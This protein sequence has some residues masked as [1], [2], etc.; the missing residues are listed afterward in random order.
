MTMKPLIGITVISPSY[1]KV[2]AEA[3]RRFKKF[4]GREVKV[5]QCADVDGYTNKLNLDLLHKGPMV[6][7]DAD[8]WLLREWRPQATGPVWTAC[9]DPLVAAPFTFACKDCDRFNLDKTRY[10]NSGLFFCDT[11]LD[12]HRA[13]FKRA[14]QMHRE[15]ARSTL[16]KAIDHTDQGWLNA[17][18]QHLNVPQAFLPFAYNYY[19]FGVT[20]GG[21]PFTPAEVFGLHG[22][23]IPP[24]HK[25]AKMRMQSAFLSESIAAPLPA[26]MALHHALSY[27]LR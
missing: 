17:A 10:F 25:A 26:A 24:Q 2:G 20:E 5:I 21:F 22:A 15:N 19:H 3:V 4:T 8:W 6:F 16:V 1:A 13:V 12:S 11:S 27:Q 7:F 14:R 18:V 9:L 23:G